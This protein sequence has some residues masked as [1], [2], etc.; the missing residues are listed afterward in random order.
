MKAPLKLTFEAAVTAL[1]ERVKEDR[2]VLAAILCGSMSH[3]TVWAKSDVDLV[4]VTIDDRKVKAESKALWAD[5][6]NV[7][8]M[9][10][11]RAEFRKV[12]EG[13]VRNSFMH[14]FLAKGRVLYSRDDSIGDLFNGLAAIGE[15]DTEIQMMG[16]ATWALPSIYKAHKWFVTRQDLEYTAL[17]LL[18]AAT[19]L[20][21]VEVLAAKQLAGREVIQQALKLNPR[22]FKTI[23]TD[24]LN[25]R[26]AKAGVEAALTAVD[27]YLAGRAGTIFAPVLGYLKE[28]GEARSATDLEDHFTKNFG[29][30]GIVTACEYLADQGLIGKASIPVR[31]TKKSSAAV[32]ELAFFHLAAR[33]TGRAR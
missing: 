3:D 13:S 4:L 12:A 6:V 26:K 20:A 11:P 29:L 28:A 15:R 17:W 8:V 19:P 25:G 23:Y 7:H 14:A 21:R 9:L 27:R 2:S 32:E 31:L 33:G 24:L 16:A 10:M 18:Y 5:G 30:E 1:I 22:F